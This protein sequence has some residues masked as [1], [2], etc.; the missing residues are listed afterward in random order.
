MRWQ[1]SLFKLFRALNYYNLDTIFKHNIKIVSFTATP[2]S[3]GQDLSLWNNS[4]IV[5]NMPVPDGY[6]SHQKLLDSNRVFQFKDLTCF[7]ANT[8]KV[9]PIAYDNISEILPFIRNMDGPKYHIIRTPR[10]NL[11]DVTIQNFNHVL[12]HS[13]WI[14]VLQKS[15]KSWKFR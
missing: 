1:Q 7:D 13:D 3:I 14:P 2:N 5:V 6:L 11:H 10:A 15:L 9:D 4:A 8:N 12:L